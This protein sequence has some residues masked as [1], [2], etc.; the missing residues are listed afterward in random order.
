MEATPP[1]RRRTFEESNLITFKALQAEPLKTVK[2]TM[3][4]ITQNKM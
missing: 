3:T 1:D 2:T 4:G